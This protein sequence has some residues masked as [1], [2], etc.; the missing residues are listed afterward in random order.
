[1]GQGCCSNCG[2]GKSEL[3]YQEVSNFLLIKSFFSIVI[4]LGIV[5][6]CKIK[7]KRVQQINI[8]LLHSFLM[9]NLHNKIIINHQKSITLI[10]K[11]RLLLPIINLS[12]RLLQIEIQLPIKILRI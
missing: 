10:E 4:S 2:D 3:P 11:L 6:K 9:F 1:M 5:I 12:C 8:F 7:I